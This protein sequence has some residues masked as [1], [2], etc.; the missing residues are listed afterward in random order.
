MTTWG[1][2]CFALLRV[3]SAMQPALFAFAPTAL[4]TLLLL[5]FSPVQPCL[6][7]ESQAKLSCRCPRPTPKT[8]LNHLAPLLLCPC[9][10][11]L[12]GRMT[13]VSC[14]GTRV[15]LAHGHPHCGSMCCTLCGS[16]RCELGCER[17]VTSRASK[18]EAYPDSRAAAV[19]E[20]YLTNN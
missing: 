2:H 10:L 11:V 9:E 1:T 13:V 15:Y 7:L 20:A 6:C 14:C 4:H 12:Q 5:P 8:L 17:A 19:F 18:H 3:S 16:C